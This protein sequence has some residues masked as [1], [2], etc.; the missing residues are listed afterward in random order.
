M[1]AFDRDEIFEE[2]SLI[3]MPRMG[4]ARL[5]TFLGIEKKDGIDQG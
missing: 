1:F 4:N 5:V 3:G 2:F